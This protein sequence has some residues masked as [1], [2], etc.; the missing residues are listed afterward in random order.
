M[1]GTLA[2]LGTGRMG[3]ALL[4]GLLR[5][6]WTRPEQIRCTVRRADRILVL[7]DGRLIE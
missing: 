4:G 7:K 1:E 2:I 5:S 6:G 3:E